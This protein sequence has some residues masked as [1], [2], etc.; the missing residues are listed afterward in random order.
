M[1]RDVAKYVFKCFTYQHVKAEHQRPAGTLQSLLIPEWKWAD[2]SMDFIMG[3]PKSTKGNDSIWEAKGVEEASWERKEDMHRDYPYLF[4]QRPPLLRLLRP[5]PPLVASSPLQEHS[6]RPPPRAVAQ[7]PPANVVCKRFW[8]CLGR[9]CYEYDHIIPFST[10]QLARNG[11]PA[12]KAPPSPSPLR[13][14]KF[15]QSFMCPSGI[16]NFPMTNSTHIKEGL[17]V[18]AKFERPLL[19]HAEVVLD[20]ESNLNHDSKGSDVRSY[21]TYLRTRPPSW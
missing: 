7:D 11:S 17:S 20:S 10:D 19:V 21:E 14:S 6:P 3:L 13:N 16:N 18:L 2:I 8:N 5:H 9:L 4:E 12:T 1:R 15:F